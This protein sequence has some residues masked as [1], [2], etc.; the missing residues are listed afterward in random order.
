MLKLVTGDRQLS[1]WSMRAWFLLRQLEVPFA[2]IALRLDTP[3]FAAT[4]AC[5]SPAARVPVLL[6][7]ALQVWDSLAICE[8]IDEQTEGRAWPRA[9]DLRARARSLSAEM[10]A[11]FVALRTQW[12]FAAAWVGRREPLDADAR[13]DL[14]RI[15]AIWSQ[16]RREHALDGPWL[17]GRF[18]AADAMYAPVALRCRTY[19][20]QLEAAAQAY[21][22]TISGN[23]HVHEWIRAAE[24]ETTKPSPVR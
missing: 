23:V 3:D 2:E 5:Y 12:P 14:N 7:G 20:A 15:E 8:Y 19:G 11:G 13:G 24:R 6:D 1:S 17:F 16:C 9:R 10:H 18:S 4:I 21:V 22:D